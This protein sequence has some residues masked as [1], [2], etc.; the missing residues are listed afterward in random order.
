MYNTKMIHVAQCLL[1]LFYWI[2][3][4]IRFNL[5]LDRVKFITLKLNVLIIK[6]FCE[7]L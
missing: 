5:S 4:V 7:L 6:Y 1:N 2:Y 3:E